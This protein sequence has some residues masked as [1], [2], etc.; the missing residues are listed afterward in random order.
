MRLNDKIHSCG[1]STEPWWLNITRLLQWASQSELFK[2]QPHQ[3]V[4]QTQ[5]IRRQELKGLRQVNLIR[6]KRP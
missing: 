6:S 2:R 5:T 4:K 1:T 3:M